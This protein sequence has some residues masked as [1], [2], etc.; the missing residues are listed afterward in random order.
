MSTE[1]PKSTKSKS[2]EDK[3]KLSSTPTK[4]KSHED[5]PK[6]SSTPTKHKSHEEKPKST[7][8][9]S[10]STPTKHKS[11]EE[12]VEESSERY[13]YPRWDIHLGE[14]ELSGLGVFAARDFKKDEVVEICPYLKIYKGHMNDECEVGDYTFEFDEESEV[15]VQGYGSMYNHHTSNN[16]DYFYEESDDMFEYIALRDI[17]KGEELTVNYG[18]EF[19]SARQEEPK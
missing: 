13:M 19:W 11:H 1:K 5:K 12:K 18:D 15:L 8:H 2:H 17:K 9:K 7:K 14:S 6:S 4:P 16:L 10:S 3:P